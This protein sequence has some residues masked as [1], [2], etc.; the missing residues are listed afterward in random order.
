[1]TTTDERETERAKDQ[2]RAELDGIRELLAALRVAQSEGK[3][4]LEGETLT[5]DEI[6]ERI[7]ESPLGVSV[8]SG[9]HDPDQVV[10]D[11]E[12][13]ILL[14]TGGPAVRITGEL[15]EHGQPDSASLE[16]QDWFTPW[17]DYP[18]TGEE[19]KEVL[20]YASTFYFGK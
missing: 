12:Y 6:T 11:E 15:D 20:D 17:V 16:Y 1:M 19:E 9:W 4:K 14:C 3:T 10:E 7:Q 18:L 8:R 13:L 2:A 5:E